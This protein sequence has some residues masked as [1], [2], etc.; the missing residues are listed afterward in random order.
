MRHAV[1]FL[2]SPA[3]RKAAPGG[4]FPPQAVGVQVGAQAVR[5]PPLAVAL[6]EQHCSSSVAPEWSCERSVD[7]VLSICDLLNAFRY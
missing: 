2:R 3:R 6:L 4:R 1:L 7:I 5:T